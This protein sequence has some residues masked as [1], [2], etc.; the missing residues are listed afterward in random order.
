MPNKIMKQW[1][2]FINKQLLP[3]LI[4][5][6][7]WEEK[8]VSMEKNLIL[9][10]F[11]LAI[12]NEPYLSYIFQGKKTIESRFSINKIAPYKNVFA[13]DIVLL[14]LSGGPV[15]GI[16]Q[17]SD[18]WHYRLDPK[19][20]KEMRK[21]YTSSLCAQDPNFWRQRERASYATLMKIRKIRK[22]RPIKFIKKDRRGWVV[23]KHRTESYELLDI[24]S[25]ILAIAG[26][27][28]S[29]KSTLTNALSKKL[30][31][32][33]VSFGSYIRD[34]AKKMGIEQNRLNLQ[35]LGAELLKNPEKLCMN[36]LSSASWNSD[37]NLLIDGIRHKNILKAL[38][39]LKPNLKIIFIYV[40]IKEDTRIKRLK[41]RTSDDYKILKEIESH[42]TEVDVINILQ[43]NADII[44]DGELPTNDLVQKIV[45]KLKS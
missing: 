17:I 32:S 23:L 45:S 21:E 24:K 38:Y 35:Q 5:D 43:N 13:N 11:H 2:T 3:E 41:K 25:T 44:V 8:I 29:G 26:K 33:A 34:E 15:I 6:S 10:G 9:D 22:I 16:C 12:F 36:V 30:S 42:S 14:K 4:G 19:S 28:G 27:I 40:D 7:F 37:Q 31:W 18:I 20:W 1:N 39:K